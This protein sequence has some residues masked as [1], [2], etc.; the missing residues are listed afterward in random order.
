MV[1][2]GSS[3]AGVAGVVEAL[4]QTW[5]GAALGPETQARLAGI[6]R[7]ERAPGGTGADARGRAHR[8]T[9]RSSWPAGSPCASSS[10]NEAWSRS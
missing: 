6:A 3:G 9:C 7:I 2:D 8:R 4:D 10:R 5:F 1:R